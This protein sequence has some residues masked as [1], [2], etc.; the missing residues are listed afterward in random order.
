M[1]EFGDVATPTIILDKISYL[2][3]IVRENSFLINLQ[4]HNI[5]MLIFENLPRFSELAQEPTSFF[6]EKGPIHIN[7]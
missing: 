4:I 2:T 7:T 6:L 3:Q 5:S 1:L